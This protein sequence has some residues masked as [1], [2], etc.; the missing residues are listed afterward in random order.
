MLIVI[1]IWN[2]EIVKMSTSSTVSMPLIPIGESSQRAVI[3]MIELLRGQALSSV[4]TNTDI[5]TGLIYEHMT[6]KPT[7]A[8]KLDKKA[9]FMIF[10]ESKDIK[11]M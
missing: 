7:V 11:N 9:T 5:I 2:S 3:F 8:Q 1:I 4:F 6:I 10:S